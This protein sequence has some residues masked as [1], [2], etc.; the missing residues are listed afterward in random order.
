MDPA[1]TINLKT[2]C[3]KP[4][5]NEY[6]SDRYP[7]GKVL[8]AQGEDWA[9]LSYAKAQDMVGYKLHHSYGRKAMGHLYHFIFY[10][11]SYR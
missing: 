2:P 5:V 1:Q 6:P 7:S 9:L 8:V 4:A 10:M 3:F 11:H